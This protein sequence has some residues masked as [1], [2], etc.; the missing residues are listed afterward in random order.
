MTIKMK[1]TLLLLNL[2]KVFVCSPTSCLSLPPFTFWPF[3]LLISPSSSSGLLCFI[4]DLINSSEVQPFTLNPHLPV[5]MATGWPPSH[6]LHSSYET[7]SD[8]CSHPQTLSPEL[9]WHTRGGS[10]VTRVQ[11]LSF[12][13]RLQQKHGHISCQWH[14]TFLSPKSGNWITGI[15]ICM[16]FPTNFSV[17]PAKLLE[18]KFKSCV[19]M[20][21][22]LM[23][24]YKK[25][26][27]KQMDIKE[28]SSSQI[29][30]FETAGGGKKTRFWY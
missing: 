21:L 17:F 6:T 18:V 11:M 22:P 12:A 13:Q 16:I 30:K 10:C 2:L 23:G 15:L 26:R 19:F 4:S 7:D 14:F 28:T 20:A 24:N 9:Y 1:R 8:P 29:S 25:K 27:I 3:L 5:H